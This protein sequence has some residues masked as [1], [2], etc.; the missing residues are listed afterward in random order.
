MCPRV[1][2]LRRT[3]ADRSG[4]APARSTLI[5]AGR[6]LSGWLATL[7]RLFSARRS[8]PGFA[9][10]NKQTIVSMPRKNPLQGQAAVRQ[11]TPARKYEL[12]ELLPRKSVQLDQEKIRECVKNQVIM[13][14]GAAGSIGSELCRQIA[15]FKPAALV[16]FD[17]AESPLFYLERELRASFPELGFCPELGNVT[18]PD[19]LRRVM[20]SHKPTLVYHAAAYKHVPVLEHQ[21]YAAIENNIFGTWNVA[22]AAIQAGVSGFVLISSDKAVAPSSVMGATKRVA[23]LIVRALHS[24]SGTSF[25]AVRF[26]N[27]LG[28]VGSVVP[29][30]EEQIAAG[31]PVTLTDREM[32]RYFMTTP[33]AVQLVLQAFAIGTGGEI[34]SLDMGEPVSILDLA[35]TMIRLSGYQPGK[36]IQI[37]CTGV[38]PGEKLMERL[39]RQDERMVSTSH[40]MIR[41]FASNPTFSVRQIRAVLDELQFAISRESRP[42]AVELLKKLVPDFEQGH[43]ESK[44]LPFWL[45]N[46]HAKRPEPTVWMEI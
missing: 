32:Y 4:A 17:M 31:G 10:H 25:N 34:F 12:E 30:F 3:S 16:A 19:T 15:H 33:E 27:V 38:R 40:P 42:Q 37:E 14:T 41:S 22:E 2:S 6:I 9:G 7:S 26:G 28:S 5:A 39:N 44:P 8:A 21:V 46:A 1:L 18:Q 23:E 20:R 13:V 43:E 45:N 35:N 24:E 29:I 36:E 11:A